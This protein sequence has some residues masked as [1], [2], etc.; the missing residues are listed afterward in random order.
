[1]L[2]SPA[3]ATSRPA[4]YVPMKYR[5]TP[6]C[7]HPPTIQNPPT[8]TDERLHSP[9]R[10]V[11]AILAHAHPTPQESSEVSPPTNWRMSARWRPSVAP[12]RGQDTRTQRYVLSRPP[13]PGSSRW[14]DD[15]ALQA[16][17]ARFPPPPGSSRWSDDSALQAS[18]ARFPPP[19]GSSRWS[20]DSALRRRPQPP[21]APAPAQLV[22]VEPLILHYG[23]ARAGPLF[24]RAAVAQNHA[25]HPHKVGG[26]VTPSIVLSY[27]MRDTK[28]GAVQ[29]IH[30]APGPPNTAC[31]P[32]DA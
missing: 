1:M 3:R 30:R 25:F 23:G 21:R 15:S 8:L 6:V 29:L 18:L 28:S 14:S 24:S 27:T 12:V 26:G 13:P 16:S 2:R 17:L 20:D 4:N 19:P 5:I 31:F 9:V 10:G 32:G 11:P 7:V 22:W